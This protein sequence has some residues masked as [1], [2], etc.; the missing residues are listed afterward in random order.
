MTKTPPNWFVRALSSLDGLLSVR[1]GPRLE[2]WVVERKAY[3]PQTE[4]GFLS[5]RFIRV[6]EFSRQAKRKQK[7]KEDLLYQARQV[8]EE[9]DS[10]LQGRRVILFARELNQDIFN[11]LCLSD[12]TRY[13]GYS[14]LADD[15]EAA[16]KREEKERERVNFN[17][18]ITRHKETYDILRFLHDHCSVQLENGVNDLK[19]LLN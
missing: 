4:V 6:M 1:W 7:E 11:N 13:G 2:Q 5:R 3:I 19:K 16:E 14:R 12:I 17:E 10:A 9:L 15:L 8:K 18:D